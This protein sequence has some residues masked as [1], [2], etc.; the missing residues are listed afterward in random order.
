[1][2]SKVPSLSGIS[3]ADIF[4]ADFSKTLQLSWMSDAAGGGVAC[5][6]ARQATNRL[7]P[8]RADKLEFVQES[9]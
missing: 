9:Q 5:Q 2:S 3:E 8:L 7:G 6:Q 4:R 1:M